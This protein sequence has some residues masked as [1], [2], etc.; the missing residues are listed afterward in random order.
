M[1]VT[2]AVV[3]MPE[4]SWQGAAGVAL[5]ATIKDLGQSLVSPV[6]HAEWRARLSS[7]LEPLRRAFAEHRAATEGDRGIYADLV[8]DAPRLARTVDDLVAEHDQL[9][10][11]MARLA[12]AVEEVSAD[13]ETLLRGALAV[14]D[15]LNRHRQSDANLVLEAYVTDIGGE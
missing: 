11:A 2:P 10:T 8:Q 3:G 12:R 9:D 1:S 15:H 4:P 13:A 5:S 6:E 14:F 7:V